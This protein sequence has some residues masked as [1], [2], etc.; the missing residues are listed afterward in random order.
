MAAMVLLLA[1]SCKKEEKNPINED[2]QEMKT[3]SAGIVQ[4]G[5]AKTGLAP[6]SGDIRYKQFWVDGDQINVNNT[7]CDLLDFTNSEHSTATFTGLVR[8]KAGDTYYAIYPANTKGGVA[9]TLDV[10]SKKATFNLPIN[11]NYAINSYVSDFAP[12]AATATVED[13]MLQFDNLCG[14]FELRVFTFDNFLSN[15][16][17]ITLQAQGSEQISGNYEYDFQTKMMKPIPSSSK[18]NQ[19]NLLCSNVEISKDPNNPTSFLFVIPPVT[20]NK[21]F[22]ISFHGKD[23]LNNDYLYSDNQ[24]VGKKI[25][26]TAGNSSYNIDPYGLQPDFMEGLKGA[27]IPYVPNS[28]DCVIMS[29]VINNTYVQVLEQGVLIYPFEGTEPSYFDEEGKKAYHPM[30]DEHGDNITTCPLSESSGSMRVTDATNFVSGK[31]FTV[32]AYARYKYVSAPG[33]SDE[34]RMWI[35]NNGVTISF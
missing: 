34:E 32:K 27:S 25:E 15:L 31:S 28:I 22:A 12:M 2:G 14:L 6:G 33:V 21:G 10:D 26:I 5:N 1:A 4:N 23:A 18:G 3:F 16:E 20:F 29:S 19:I 17:Y 35:T 13:D 24:F 9:A 11:Q 8:P 30:T 7:T